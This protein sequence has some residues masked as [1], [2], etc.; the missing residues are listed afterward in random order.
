[1]VLI[2]MV[3]KQS[4]LTLSSKENCLNYIPENIIV[5]HW[6]T[7]GGVGEV[8]S[9]EDTKTHYYPNYIDLV[10]LTTLHASQPFNYCQSLHG[11]RLVRS[12]HILV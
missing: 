1:M 5:T 9:L 10:G 7:S 4:G 12:D 8:K 11:Y 3:E 6:K 2:S